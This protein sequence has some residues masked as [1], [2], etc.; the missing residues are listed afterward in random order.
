[1]HFAGD[2]LFSGK[3]EAELKKHGYDYPYKHLGTAFLEDDL[4]VL[5]LETPVTTGESWRGQ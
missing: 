5:N 2:T 4:T 3:V 1:M